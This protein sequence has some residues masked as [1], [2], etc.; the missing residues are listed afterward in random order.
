[1]VIQPYCLHN[2]N[3][4]RLAQ[5]AHISNKQESNQKKITLFRVE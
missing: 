5:C 4:I 1:M 2:L 3:S